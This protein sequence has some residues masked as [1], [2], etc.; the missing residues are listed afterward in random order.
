MKDNITRRDFLNGTQVAIGGSFF[1]SSQ[2]LF[3]TSS[4]SLP[5]NYYP[6]ALTGLRGSHDGSWEV[7]HSKVLGKQRKKSKYEEKYDLVIDLHN[8]IRSN[9]IKF[10][11]A[12]KNYT[13]D[14]QSFRRW[15]LTNFKI[16]SK[17]IYQKK[18]KSSVF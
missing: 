9:F 11:L 2:N 8:N 6:P 1:L 18:F 3:G 16:Y 10:S 17:S 13:Y 14:K 12:V 15:L 7:M 5:N 4:Y